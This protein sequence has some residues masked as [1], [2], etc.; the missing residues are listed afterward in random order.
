KNIP[1]EM[2]LIRNH[3]VGRTFI[4]PDQ[5]GRDES[6]KQKFNPVVSTLKGKRVVLVDDSIVRGTTM[7]KI[8]GMLWN[9][10]VAEIHLRIASPPVRFPCFYGLD[11]NTKEELLANRMDFADMPEY[12]R[13]TSLKY[14]DQKDLSDCVSNTDGNF[15]FACFDGDYPIELV[16]VSF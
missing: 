13:V 9:A 3:Y 11:T 6:V 5:R 8:A 15:C 1:F 4:K 14:L 16:D 7:R 2:S 12:L 10:G